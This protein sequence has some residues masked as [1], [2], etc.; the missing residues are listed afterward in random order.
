MVGLGFEPATG[1]V[2]IPEAEVSTTVICSFLL[3]TLGELFLYHLLQGR[4]YHL[5]VAGGK[6]DGR[7]R[8]DTAPLAS[9]GQGWI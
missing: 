2:A 8:L 1:F 9:S 5:L 4:C 3:G 6:S 7:G